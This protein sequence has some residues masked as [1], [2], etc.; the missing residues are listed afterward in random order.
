MHAAGP[1]TV[2]RRLSSFPLSQMALPEPKTE[3][4]LSKLMPKSRPGGI[5][6][7]GDRR[8][9]EMLPK[10]K[11]KCC[12]GVREWGV[13]DLK[14]STF[15]NDKGDEF[16]VHCCG[17]CRQPLPL[18]LQRQPPLLSS[19]QLARME[20]SRLAALARRV[21]AVGSKRSHDEICV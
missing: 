4:E 19:E 12:E 5:V 6:R 13:G 16:A 11:G 1:L 21:Q 20:Q 3:A 17:A 9:S 14:P 2:C 18:P 15:V 7:K 10:Y 8:Y